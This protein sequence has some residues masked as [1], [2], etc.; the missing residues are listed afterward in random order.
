[1]D[2]TYK[3]CIPHPDRVLYADLSHKQTIH[4]TEAELHI[5]DAF[6]LKVLGKTCVYP[7]CQITELAHLPVY[8]RLGIYVV[9]LN[10]V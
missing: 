4:P 7:G 9:V 1:M 6:I 8:A 10:A 2:Q 5:F 3:V